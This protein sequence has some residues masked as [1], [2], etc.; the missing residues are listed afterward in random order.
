[1][2]RFLWR[3]DSQLCNIRKIL[4]Y[5]DTAITLLYIN[6]DNNFAMR[7]TRTIHNK[8]ILIALLYHTRGETLRNAYSASFT[9]PRDVIAYNYDVLYTNEW[10]HYARS[11]VWILIINA[12][13]DIH[14]LKLHHLTLHHL[15]PPP[16]HSSSSSLLLLTPPPHSSSSLIL[17]TPPPHSS[18]SLLLLTPPPHSS[19]TSTTLH[20]RKNPGRTASILLLTCNVSLHRL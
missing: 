10:R 6:F 5:K 18:S 17:L 13:V 2:S 12:V 11:F 19:T 3:I 7:G 9:R 15:T 4:Q 16:P 20:H 14:H 8:P 1:M